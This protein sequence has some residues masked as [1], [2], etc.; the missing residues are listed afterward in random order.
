MRKDHSKQIQNKKQ[1]N[2]SLSQVSDKGFPSVQ[3]ATCVVLN[4]NWQLFIVTVYSKDTDS[5]NDFEI[6]QY[7]MGI[8][9]SPYN[10]Q[11]KSKLRCLKS[12]SC[13]QAKIL[14]NLM[15]CEH[16]HMLPCLITEMKLSLQ[17]GFMSKKTETQM[18]M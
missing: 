16:Q 6:V 10:R 11:K 7:F 3:V 1:K 13:G 18:F 12:F 2:G 14:R 15:E 5:E 9:L 17:G 4:G 8:L